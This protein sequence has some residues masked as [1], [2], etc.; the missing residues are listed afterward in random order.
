MATKEFEPL[1]MWTVKP[2]Y[3]QFLKSELKPGGE[4][5]VYGQTLDAIKKKVDSI[6]DKAYLVEIHKDGKSMSARMD[7]VWYDDTDG[8]V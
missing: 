2:F 1:L 5:W 3:R 8:M 7:G 6:N 4:F